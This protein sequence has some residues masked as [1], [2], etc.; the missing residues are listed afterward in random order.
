[1]KLQWSIQSRHTQLAL[2]HVTHLN[3]RRVHIWPLTRLD[4]V[5]WSFTIISTFNHNIWSFRSFWNNHI[6]LWEWYLIFHL[7]EIA[8]GFLNN[9]TLYFWSLSLFPSRILVCAIGFCSSISLYIW[10]ALFSK[11]KKRVERYIGTS[12]CMSQDQQNHSLIIHDK[13]EDLFTTVTLISR[14]LLQR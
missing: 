11:K 14:V 1:M 5:I 4:N 13:F 10:R 6:S 12:L 3:Y 8:F 2:D 7:D 9:H